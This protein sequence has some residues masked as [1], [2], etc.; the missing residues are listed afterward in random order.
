MTKKYFIIYD[1]KKNNNNKNKKKTKTTFDKIN[2]STTCYY[3]NVCNSAL[4]NLN[5]SFI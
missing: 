2:I 3:K 4:K 1:E 5:I